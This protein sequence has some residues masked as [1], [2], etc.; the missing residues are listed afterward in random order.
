MRQDDSTIPTIARQVPNETAGEAENALQMGAKD[1]RGAQASPT[2]RVTVDTSNT[3]LS[4]GGNGDTGGAIE[5]RT[6]QAVP[7]VKVEPL[8][9][10]E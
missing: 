6:P 10:Q 9:K 8:K 7:A 3:K 2:H 4:Y 1:P 5:V